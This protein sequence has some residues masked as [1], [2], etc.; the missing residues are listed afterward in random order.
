MKK[1]TIITYPHPTLRKKAQPIHP[2]SLS[3]MQ[4]FFDA[5][6]E[7]MRLADGVGLA[8]TQVNVTDRVCVVAH[9]DGPLVLINPELFSFSFR[10]ETQEEGCLSIPGVWGTVKRSKRLR[11][12]A[13]TREG[14]TIEGI[15]EGLF[16]RV[17]Q[18][19]IDHLNGVL[20]ID[21]MQRITKGTLPEKP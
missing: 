15:A 11:F 17:L 4:S 9:Q 3:S 13:L 8:A 14:K 10:K 6:I 16:A 20:F 12:R 19:E 1:L 2:E 18:H 5:M 21:R 7:T